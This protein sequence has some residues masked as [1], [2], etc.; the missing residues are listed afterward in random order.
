MVFGTVANLLY[1]VGTD[2][3]LDVALVFCSQVL[4]LLL[5]VPENDEHQFRGHSFGLVK[6]FR[7]SWSL[8]LLFFLIQLQLLI[9][10]GSVVRVGD[11]FLQGVVLVHL[12][13]FNLIYIS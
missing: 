11:N 7:L 4:A 9:A 2:G 8:L 3:P 13:A 1:D 5:V 10:D 12:R 6:L